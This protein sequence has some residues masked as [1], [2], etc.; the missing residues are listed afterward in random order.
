M[1]ILYAEVKKAIYYKDAKGLQRLLD[2]GIHPVESG[3]L[4]ELLMASKIH[5]YDEEFYKEWGVKFVEPM[6]VGQHEVRELFM[7]AISLNSRELFSLLLDKGLIPETA[8]LT[9]VLKGKNEHWLLA[10]KSR[11][12]AYS[13]EGANL[14]QMMDLY[15]AMVENLRLESLYD[16]FKAPLQKMIQHRLE[17]S[18]WNQLLCLAAKF[19]NALFV[20]FAL[21]MGA[22]ANHQESDGRTPLMISSTLSD[23]QSIKVLMAAG[24]EKGMM[25]EKGRTAAEYHPLHKQLEAY[26]LL[27]EG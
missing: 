15:E 16:Y 22:E 20:E 3:I 9:Q 21:E 4:S 5:P 10:I 25:D 6:T 1:T 26:L 23:A 17:Q 13:F 27:R 8:V 18:K 7:S 14:N 11:K 2:E 12:R 19:S 24:A